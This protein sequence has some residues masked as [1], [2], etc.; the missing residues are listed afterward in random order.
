MCFGLEFNL[1]NHLTS[2]ATLEMVSLLYLLQDFRLS[3]EP[4]R[5]LNG[6]H[7]FM[8]KRAYELLTKEDDEDRHTQIIWQF[9]VPNKIKLFACFS[10]RVGSTQMKT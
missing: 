2:V 6:G 1:C 9:K 5:F 10:S 8:T 7:A 3:D 4:D